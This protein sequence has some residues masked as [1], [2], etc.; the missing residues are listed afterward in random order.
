MTMPKWFFIFA[1]ALVLAAALAGCGRETAPA[2]GV[3]A[4][5]P[6]YHCPMHPT[7]VSDR[8]GT[9]PICKMDLVPIPQEEPVP[10]ASSRTAPAS[11][12]TDRATVTLSPE[13]RRLLGVRSEVVSRGRLERSL[14]ASGRIAIDERRVHHVHTKYEAWVESLDVDFVGQTVRK[15]D[16]LATLYAPE[17]VATQQEYLLALAAQRR[18]AGSSI[19]SVASGG[20]DLLEAARRRLLAWDVHPRD[21]ARLEQQGTVQRSL[22]LYAES[23][24]VVTAKVAVHGMR[25]TPADVLFD[26]ADLSRVWVLADLAE[27]EMAGVRSGLPAEVALSHL[28]GR[29]WKGPVTW[30]S[31]LVDPATRTVR[32]RVELTNPDLALRPEAFA[33]VRLRLDAGDALLVPDSAVLTTG[34]RS[35]VFVDHDDGR[36]EPRAIVVGSGGERGRIVL[37]GLAEGERVLTSANFLIDSESSLKAA[38]SDLT[39]AA[40]A[41]GHDHAERRAEPEAGARPHVH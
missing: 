35:L 25:V 11:E 32:V 1:T 29:S 19:E 36:L 16:R 17:L 7:Y 31:P 12:P 38:L 2:P 5:R 22:A 41:A 28:P 10:A 3:A 26:I 39:A 37:S 34:T 4:A 30:V 13:R 14:R 21:I 33:E 8:P 20:R 23:G 18:L 9:C 27:S 24:G 15:G 40:G 6:Q